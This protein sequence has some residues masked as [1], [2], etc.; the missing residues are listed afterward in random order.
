MSV[1]GER[2]WRTSEDEWLPVHTRA[3]V[4]GVQLPPTPEIVRNH[5]DRSYS[6]DGQQDGW[7]AEFD[8]WGVRVRR[9]ASG[10]ILNPRMSLVPLPGEE[11]VSYEERREVMKQLAAYKKACRHRKCVAKR[12]R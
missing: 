3:R 6:E 1:R 10:A 12:L 2:K 4:M 7:L 8:N 5:C 11:R 9:D